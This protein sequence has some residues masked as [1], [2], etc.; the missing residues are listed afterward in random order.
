MGYFNTVTTALARLEYTSPM[1]LKSMPHGGSEDT[2]T[3]HMT[4]EVG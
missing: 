3:S 2:Q 1:I 4:I